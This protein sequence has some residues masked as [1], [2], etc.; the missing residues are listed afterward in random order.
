[1]RNLTLSLIAVVALTFAAC[2]TAQKT[3]SSAKA[4]DTPKK[5]MAEDKAV[6]YVVK[7]VNDSIASPRMELTGLVG[8]ANVTVNFGSPKVKGRTIWGELVKYDKTWRMGAN[9]ATTFE[10]SKDLK[11]GGDGTLPAGKYALF[12][13]PSAEGAWKVVFNSQSDQ[14][15][16]YNKDDAKDVLSVEATPSMT[17]EVAEN[18]TFAIKDGNLVMMWEKLVLPVSMATI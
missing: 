3:E 10:T 11:V 14:W 16:A 5:E 17:E 7:V 8:D 15:G 1:M 9:E 13:V 18:L 12:T 2:N 6:P 4:D